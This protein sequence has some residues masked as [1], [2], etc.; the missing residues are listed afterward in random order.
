MTEVARE[1]YSMAF[2]RLNL[3]CCLELLEPS[4][5]LIKALTKFDSSYVATVFITFFFAIYA[6]SIFV[7]PLRSAAYVT[8][9]N[10][11]W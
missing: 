4:E 11:E 1:V 6:R 7:L 9:I 8:I 5:V 3:L 10:Q 2:N